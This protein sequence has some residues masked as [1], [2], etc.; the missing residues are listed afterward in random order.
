VTAPK[1]NALMQ[2]GQALVE[3]MDR[4]SP[5]RRRVVGALI[6]KV[7]I[8]EDEEGEIAA[9]SLIDDISSILATPEVSH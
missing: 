6:R 1:D 5:D 2:D 4:L 7:A 3:L 9:L 8:V